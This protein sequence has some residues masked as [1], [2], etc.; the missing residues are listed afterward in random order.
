M[1][2]QREKCGLFRVRLSVRPAGIVSTP[3]QGYS[4]ARRWPLRERPQGTASSKSRPLIKKRIVFRQESHGYR[5]W[6]CSSD[7]TDNWR[8]RS[9]SEKHSNPRSRGRLSQATV[10]FV[11][12]HLPST[13]ASSGMAH[14]PICVC[15]PIETNS[16]ERWLKLLGYNSSAAREAR[17]NGK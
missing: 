14:N 8:G 12:V 9:D 1:K 15:N 11:S 13:D 10:I 2:Q 7:K 16:V 17:D 6:A 4:L 5:L 3:A